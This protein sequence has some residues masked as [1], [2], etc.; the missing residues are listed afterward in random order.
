MFSVLIIARSDG[1]GVPTAL[2]SSLTASG[3][4][5]GVLVGSGL[6]VLVSVGLIVAVDEDDPS[7]S[8]A[9]GV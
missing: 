6:G 4:A 1:S 2:M 3:L 5:V 9:A 8:V 7:V